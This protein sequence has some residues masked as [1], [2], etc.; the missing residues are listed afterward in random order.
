VARQMMVRL[1]L[2]GEPRARAAWR[3]N[4]VRALLF[5]SVILACAL[6]SSAQFQQP[7]VFSTSGAVMT[8]NDQTG[9]LS[10]VAGSPYAPADFQTLDVQ[11]RFLFG[12]GTN[13]IHMFQVNSTTGAYSE[14]PNS[15]FASG[16]TNQPGFIAV[17]PSGQYIAVVNRASPLQGEGSM[18]TFRI[19]SANLA[20]VPVPGSFQELDS[21]VIGAGIDHLNRRFY[22]FLA[23]NPNIP[24]LQ[25]DSELNNYA[26]DPQTGL[27]SGNTFLVG[28]EGRCFAMDT[29]GR[30]LILGMGRLEGIVGILPIAADTGVP[31]GTFAQTSL[32][33]GSFPNAI[34]TEVTGNFVYLTYLNSTTPPVHIFAIDPQTQM[35]T[36]TAS[37]P[38]PGFS[39]VPA[40]MADPTGPFMYES[41]ATGTT[42][43]AFMTDPLT[44]YFSAVAGTT[45]S[46]PGVNG[47]FVFSISPGQQKVVGPAASLTP[48]TLFLGSVMVGTPSAAEP[49]LL[50]STGDQALSLN[51]ISITGA[52]ASEFNETDNC[53][54]PTV[55]QP[56]KACTIMV[57]FTPSATGT[58]QAV[59]ATTDNAPGPVQTVQLSG[60]GVAPPPPQ[61][62]VTLIPGTLTFP[63]ISQGT[64][65][66]SLTVT[67]TNSGNATLHITSVVVGGNNSKD[68]SG[69]NSC[70]GAFAAKA[71][72]TI[73]VTFA[74]L[75][76]GERSETITLT[77]DAADSPQVIQASGNAN[78][79]FTAGA[80]PGGSMS[81]SVTAGQ[82]AQYQL[83]LT[84][85][86]GYS[87][88]VAFACSGAPVGAV[89]HAPASVPLANGMP[90]SFTV[91]VSTS[92]GAIVP[93]AIRV[94][95]RPFSELRWLPLP[96]FATVLLM[97]LLYRWAFERK[98]GAKRVALGGALIVMAAFA[99]LNMG[100]CG[101]GSAAVLTP[102]PV[103]T[104]AGTSTI[105]ITPTAMS[106]TGQP[107]QLQPIQLTLKVN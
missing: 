41:D 13:S 29:Q 27:V 47:F 66:S 90:A 73:T 70:V 42:V 68:F 79:A 11:G 102:P 14:V 16:N 2:C 10:T 92:G 48:S 22:V 87:G 20:L 93:P 17:E 67:V 106:S 31:G 69:V 9:V 86:V 95:F 37:T 98:A 63:T 96:A 105:V 107:L 82:S 101:G 19:D 32:G 18:E 52:N 57:M 7:L 58:R 5:L 94:R 97:M 55:L 34:A 64:T 56:S 43:Q 81:A 89:C 21:T 76:A 91:T 25:T 100:G 28:T 49:I 8:R 77:D 35:L 75:A 85:G 74:P 51:A 59:L 78:P 50:T 53:Q 3:S 71:G 54:A 39:S 45:I 40:L 65:S 38:L 103:I 33:F 4:A 88:S 36:E 61:P 99:G 72:C 15:P 44:G 46:A 83:Q 60:V 24:A 12:L 1:C 30:F 84:P 104:P 23:P 6:P 80:A 62:A 26:I